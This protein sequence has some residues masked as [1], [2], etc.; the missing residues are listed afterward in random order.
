MPSY[1]VSY[2]LTATGTITVDDVESED[3]AKDEIEGAI[4]GFSGFSK[5]D[6]VDNADDWDIDISEVKEA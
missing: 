6:I 2:T 3:D 5:S 1:E 4:N